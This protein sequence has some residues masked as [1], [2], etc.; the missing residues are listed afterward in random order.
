MFFVPSTPLDV[1]NLLNR[2]VAEEMFIS[3]F[4]FFLRYNNHIYCMLGIFDRP[5]V[6]KISITQHGMLKIQLK[7]IF[8]FFDF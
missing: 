2:Q 3:F 5:I 4:E 6:K 7:K 8:F 1:K